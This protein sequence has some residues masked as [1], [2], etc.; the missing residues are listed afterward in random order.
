M[1]AKT[2]L[3]L[4]FLLASISVSAQT[5]V[6]TVTG[7]SGGGAYRSPAKLIHV[8]ANPPV[9]GQ[10]FDRWTG[11]ANLLENPF[12][13]HTRVIHLKRNATLTATYKTAPVWTQTNESINGIGLGFYFPPDYKAV[14]VRFH[15]SGGNYLTFFNEA[16][17]R[18]FANYAVADGYAVVSLDSADRV[19]KQWDFNSP[20]ASNQDLQNVVLIFQTLR[21]RGILRANTPVFALGFSNG[22]TFASYAAHTLG[23]KAAAIY[24][25]TGLDSWMDATTVPHIWNLAINDTRLGA[26]GYA[27]SLEQSENLLRRGIAAQHYTNLP[28]PVY[29]ERFWRLAGLTQIDSAAIYDGL[30]NGGILDDKNF[31]INSPRVSDWREQIPAPYNANAQLMN[32]IGGQLDNCWAEHQF[33]SESNYRTIQFFNAHL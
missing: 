21:S 29:A 26:D 18:D 23:G 10:V 13:A 22:G 8:W 11:D 27:L 28:S 9:A 7:G 12:D 20:T 3:F 17:D 19:N 25:S 32:D 15:G 31:Q 6:L 5:K 2:L 33:F 16:E 30:K 1:R 14:I 24:N 4:I